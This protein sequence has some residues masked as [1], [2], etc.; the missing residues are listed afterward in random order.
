[1][2]NHATDPVQT[3]GAEQLTLHALISCNGASPSLLKSNIPGLTVVGTN[4]ATGT[5]RLQF[6][7][8]TLPAGA[9]TAVVNVTIGNA[10]SVN[11]IALYSDA[12]LVS[13]GQLDVFVL[14]AGSA[15]N[16][17]AGKLS[18]TMTFENTSG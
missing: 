3:L 10:T 1:M 16:L 2:F 4:P 5:Y 15:A 14:T 8:G 17:A 13:A 12:N 18:V 7:A 6:A 11:S 9:S